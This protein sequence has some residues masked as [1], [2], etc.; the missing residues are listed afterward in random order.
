MTQEFLDHDV[1][2]GLLVDLA[3]QRVLGS[4][5]WIDSSAWHGPLTLPRFVPT[6]NEQDSPIGIGDEGPHRADLH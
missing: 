6:K 5:A 3:D 2:A 4:L 1:Q